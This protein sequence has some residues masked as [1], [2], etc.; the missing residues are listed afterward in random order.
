MRPTIITNEQS[1]GGVRPDFLAIDKNMKIFVSGHTGVVGA[2]IVRHLREKG[3]SSI[4]GRTRQ[5]LDLLDQRAVFDFLEQEKP[6]YMFVAAGRVGGVHANN[7]YRGEF[8]YEN[9]VI[10]SNLIHGARLAGIK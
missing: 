4:L 3:Y 6:D 10:E 7:T 8:I 2:A 1:S 5:E 9:V